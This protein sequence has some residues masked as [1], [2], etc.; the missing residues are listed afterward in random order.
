MNVRKGVW[1]D[2]SI[3][4]GGHLTALIDRTLNVGWKERNEWLEANGWRTPFVPDRR[5]SP[6]R[7]R[8]ARALAE[9]RQIEREAAKAARREIDS[10]EATERR[11]HAAHTWRDGLAAVGTPAEQYLVGRG[12]WPSFEPLPS[13]IRWRPGDLQAPNEDGVIGP[14]GAA[15]ILVWRIE[16]AATSRGTAVG[17]EA[18]DATGGRLERR[19][20]RTWGVAS[21]GW[22][23][24]IPV[25]DPRQILLVEGAMDALAAAAALLGQRTLIAAID[26]AAVSD[27]LVA[28]IAARH[29]PVRLLADGDVAGVRGAHRSA[30]RLRAAGATTTISACAQDE[31]PAS[32]IAG[33][34]G[35][36]RAQGQD[37]RDAWTALR[38][39]WQQTHMEIAT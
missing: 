16:D 4:T 25:P 15:G 37:E 2:H 29:L 31:D 13:S 3:A 23:V 39:A 20:R 34:I 30:D 11:W 1:R 10:A 5:P 21:G 22:F 26:G 27:R 7:Q 35:E 14:L 17:I 12:A 18:L 38:H 33:W 24:P 19:Y 8:Q 32:Y 36:A 28:A 6:Q 9:Q